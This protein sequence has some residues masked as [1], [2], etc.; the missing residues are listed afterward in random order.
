MA[1]TTA[2]IVSK[3]PAT[4]EG[5]VH[6]VIAFT[7]DAG[8]P[9]VQRDFVL[10]A[11]S[12]FVGL[13]TFVRDTIAA[14]TNRKAITSDARL[15]V[16]QTIPPAAA[17]PAPTAPQIALQQYFSDAARLVHMKQLIDAGGMLASNTEYVALQTSVKN[18]Y[19][20]AYAAAF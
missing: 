17:D 5:R 19:Q 9:P 15:V 3:D 14:L 2:T 6:L 20:V 12:T 1:Y 4:Q 18:A 13:R 11:D 16:G 7:G 10:D 8:E